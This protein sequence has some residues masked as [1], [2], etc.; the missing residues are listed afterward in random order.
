MA[1]N[2]CHHDWVQDSLRK[3]HDSFPFTAKH[4]A[5]WPE[6]AITKIGSKTAPQL[7]DCFSLYCK[8]K[9]TTPPTHPPEAT[10]TEVLL[11]FC[12]M[13]KH[14]HDCQDEYTMLMNRN[15]IYIY[16]YI[17]WAATSWHTRIQPYIH[18]T[19][20]TCIRAQTHP[21]A[22]PPRKSGSAAEAGAFK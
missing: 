22:N 12:F 11:L 7:N 17:W 9:T 1:R 18:A 4:Q 16:I 21:L 10:R 2:G 3:K 6:M 8:A 15:M 14:P 5:T 19:Y 20:D 13:H